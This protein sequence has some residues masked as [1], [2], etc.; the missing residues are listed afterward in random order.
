MPSGRAARAIGETR[1]PD[2][3]M[4]YMDAAEALFIRLGYDGASIRAISARAKM[5]LAT[6]VYHW[7]TKE[8]L[9]REVC[10]RRFG[11][12]REEQ[13]RRLRACEARFD[14]LGDGDLDEVLRALVEPSMLADSNA[15]RAHQTRLLYGRVLTDPSPIVLRI[16]AEIF[17]DASDLFFKLTRKCLANL[18]QNSFYWRY[19]SAIGVFTFAQSFSNR[20]A[21]AHHI[22][23]SS[24][25]WKMVTDEIIAFMAAGFRDGAT[26]VACQNVENLGTP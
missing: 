4:R 10:L 14:T 20:I 26:A 23:D 8:A 7:G 3:A 25:D 12:I 24:S 13:L 9:F 17:A 5:N 21:Y 11:A 15:K 16:T 6:V 18:P 22:D 19:V 1:K 2:T